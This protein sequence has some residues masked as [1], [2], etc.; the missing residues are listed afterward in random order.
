MEG[1]I[2]LSYANSLKLQFFKKMQ[3]FSHKNI[4]FKIHT[5]LSL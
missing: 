1:G 4:I 5:L 2:H 3:L